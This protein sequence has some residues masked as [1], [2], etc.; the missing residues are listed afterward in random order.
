MYQPT[1]Y[2]PQACNVFCSNEFPIYGNFLEL[3]IKACAR[4]F[5][6]IFIFSPN[7]SPSKT[8]ENIFYFIEKALFVHEIFNFS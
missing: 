2:S 6:Q 1:V 4:N 8:I 3:S 7:V 5:Y